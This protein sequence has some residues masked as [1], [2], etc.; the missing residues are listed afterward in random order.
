MGFKGSMNPLKLYTLF[1]VYVISPDFQ[2][3]PQPQ[4]RHSSKNK[5]GFTSIIVTVYK[6]KELK[7]YWICKAMRKTI[8]MD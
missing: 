2:R 3:T 7:P 6:C 8:N 1:C 4:S 5:C